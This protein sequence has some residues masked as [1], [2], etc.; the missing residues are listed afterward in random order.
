MIRPPWMTRLCGAAVLIA[1]LSPPLPAA[2]PDEVQQAIDRAQKFLLD[3]RNK[4]G[5]WEEV[6]KALTG[7]DVALRTD[8]KGR[9][10]LD[11]VA[12]QDILQGTADRTPAAPGISRGPV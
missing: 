3:H 9:Q 12:E 8:P 6:D 11:W 10:S 5:T 2:T 4:Q 1:I 7:A